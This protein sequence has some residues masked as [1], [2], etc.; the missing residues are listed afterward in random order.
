MLSKTELELDITTQNGWADLT[1]YFASGKTPPASAPT[2]DDFVTG[3]SAYTFDVGDY[4]NILFHMN[5]DYKPNTAFFPHVHWSTDGVETHEVKWEVSYSIAKGHQQGAL[6]EFSASSVINLS[7]S[8]SGLAYQHMVVEH[9]TGITDSKL[10][11]DSLI[12]MRIKRVTNGA[13]DLTDT[14][15]GL[16]ADIHY[17]TDRMATLN[18]LPNFYGA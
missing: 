1:G 2:W 3:Q 12:M 17:E 7:Q 13:T 11:V 15:F 16:T 4:I 18:R 8:A 6:S 5:H 10:E 9:E 14:V